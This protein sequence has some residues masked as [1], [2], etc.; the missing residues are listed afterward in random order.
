[1]YENSI[2]VILFRTN[3]LRLR[4]IPLFAQKIGY[5]L[6]KF[7]KF[8]RKIQPSGEVHRFC[9]FYFPGKQKLYY[10]LRTDFYALS[11]Q[12]WN[13]FPGGSQLSGSIDMNPSRAKLKLQSGSSTIKV[14][15]I[16]KAPLSIKA[17]KFNYSMVSLLTGL[18][19]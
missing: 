19:Y 16:F 3:Y 17:I 12:P 2:P 4:D 6:E 5:W 13:N 7:Q 11:F 1:M 10:H 9:L 15:G 14:P 18:G 8:Y